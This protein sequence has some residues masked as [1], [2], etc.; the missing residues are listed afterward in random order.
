VVSSI[1]FDNAVFVNP[2]T[3]RRSWFSQRVTP[4]TIL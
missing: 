3:R 4:L 2:A 1:G